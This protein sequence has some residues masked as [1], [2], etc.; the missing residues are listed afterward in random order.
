MLIPLQ[1][2]VDRCGP[3]QGH[4]APWRVAPHWGCN[5][6][7]RSHHLAVQCCSFSDL[8]LEHFQGPD[9]HFVPGIQTHHAKVTLTCQALWLSVATTYVTI[10]WSLGT[11][12]IQ[13]SAKDSLLCVGPGMPWEIE[14]LRLE[15]ISKILD[16]VNATTK[17]CPWVYVF[18]YFQ[19]WW[20]NHFIGHPIP[21]SDNPFPEE[22]FPSIQSK[23]PLMQF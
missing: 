14:L 12:P 6:E 22:I 2:P 16:T 21:M 3:P 9:S 19:E 20:L 5:S 17:S 1:Y 23:P 7:Y 11:W 18:K 10:C 8:Q 4:G 13:H 15:K